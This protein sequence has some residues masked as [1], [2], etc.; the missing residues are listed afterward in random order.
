[1][2]GDHALDQT[3]STTCRLATPSTQVEREL[4]D[5]FQYHLEH[6]VDD[7]VSGLA[8]VDTL[9]QDI[10]Y[11]A[12]RL[13]RA[14]DFT[15]PALLTLAVGIG[16]TTSMFSV[17]NGVLIRPLPYHDPERLVMLWTDDVS[18][19]I[20]EEGVWY[21]NF[22]DWRTRGRSF[23]DMAI[24]SR[25]IFATITD[26]PEPEEVQPAVVSANLF[27]VLGVR[28]LLGRTFSPQEVEDGERV[29]ILSHGFWQ[30]RFGGS[31]NA[32]G[33][34]VEI[35]GTPWRVI[36]V[37][38]A[39]FQFPT[40]EI[41]LWQQLTAFRAWPGL[42]HERYTDWGRVVGRLKPA[43]TVAHAQAEM[44][45]I[46]DSLALAYPPVGPE[47]ADFAGFNVRVVSLMLQ[48][49]GREVPRALWVMF[50]AVVFVLLIA[51]ANVANLLLARGTARARELAV[52]QAL[53]A[54]RGRL[55]RQLITESLLL[56]FLAGAL[57]IGIAAL[58]LNA[59]TALGPSNLPRLKD[60][61]MDVGVV[62]FALAIS[63]LACV[64]SS[65]APS[66][67][68]SRIAALNTRASR[69]D[70]GTGRAQRLVVITTFA[71]SSVLLCGAG[72]LIRSFLRA[73][74]VDPGF[75][76]DGVLTMRVAARDS[77][78]AA[79]DFFR[80]VL[81][82]SRAIPG[83][84]RAGIVEDVLQR[85]N[86]D[87]RVVLEGEPV[88]P[89]EALSGDAASPEYFEAVGVRLR[90]G[91]PFSDRDR[92]GSMPVA[93][94]NETMARHFWHG[95]DPIG[96]RFRAADAAP[97]DQWLTVV[98]VIADMRRQGLEREPIAQVFWPHAQ[99]PVSTA[100][101]VLRT[102]IEPAQLAT[103]VRTGIREVDRRVPVSRIG[104]LNDRLDASLSSRRFQSALLILFS[105]IAL[106][107]A[108]T[109]IYGLM[110][111]TIALRTQEIGVRIALGAQA[112][113]ILWM[114]LRQSIGVIAAG[115][116]VGVTGALL[117]SRVL[118]SLLFGI[119]PVDPVTF[120]TVPLLIAA[121]AMAAC[122]LPA[123]RAA[124]LDPIVALRQE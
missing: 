22:E 23:E 110:H 16:A 78:P 80:R 5:E 51:C 56:A 40:A 89:T 27:S 113:E 35:S 88:Q 82:R 71:L 44:S 98:G 12:R 61:Q 73:Q 91:R 103:A 32:L 64:F 41:A 9:R 123:R 55:L 107:L 54:T 102:A 97:D 74:A 90:K 4:N 52:R 118:S 14:V 45:A 94:V 42:Q 81:D 77:G 79:V 75:R 47:A 86:P 85:R 84:I 59:L 53:G 39:S 109:G 62:V 11:A 36:G 111:Y 15:A 112:A 105:A 115:V 66:V 116:A 48:V 17:V 20:H 119:S 31:P 6:L 29:V 96:R 76:A 25:Q 114:I 60:V 19:N 46:G 18:H 65:V 50:G 63:L 87:Y 122:L 38:P 2:R 69:A 104:T 92:A 49:T 28:P 120:G 124:K 24:C 83:V 58:T 57:G 99:R 8:L 68:L 13:R 95:T 106:G 21:V 67:R 93:I 30:R 43:V 37:M 100:D 10:T 101:L 34:S 33:Q 121:V 70:V 1:M 108:A 72:L 117:L 26:G 7:Y 3:A